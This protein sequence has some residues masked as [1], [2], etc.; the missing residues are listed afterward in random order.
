[1]AMT[2]ERPTLG[3]TWLADQLE[4]WALRREKLIH[5]LDF[6]AAREARELAAGARALDLARERLATDSDHD[7]WSAE[8]WRLRKRVAALLEADAKSAEGRKSQPGERPST[9]E[10]PIVSEAGAGAPRAGRTRAA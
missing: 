3:C 8:W 9:G 10:H 6:R 5:L 4:T 7:A 2:P 1:M